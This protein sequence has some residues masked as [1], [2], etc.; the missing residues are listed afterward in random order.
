MFNREETSPEKRA[1]DWHGS[2]R[3]LVVDEND[4]TPIG[5]PLLDAAAD[6][7]LFVACG[8]DGGDPHDDAYVQELVPSVADCPG[9]GRT[10]KAGSHGRNASTSPPLS[11][12]FG[13]GSQ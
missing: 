7:Q 3:R 5:D 9:E 11:I 1:G 12:G 10:L 2:V 8:D 4:I 13:G 6:V